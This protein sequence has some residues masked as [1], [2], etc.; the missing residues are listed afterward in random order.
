MIVN[1]TV[2]PLGATLIGTP[3]GTPGAPVPAEGGPH[4]D[5]V[6]AAHV[7][8]APAASSWDGSGSEKVPVP[9][10]LL[11]L[12]TVTVYVTGC[13]GIGF[14]GECVFATSSWAGMTKLSSATHWGRPSSHPVLV[15]GVTVAVLMTGVP[16]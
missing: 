5:P 8:V 7:Q 9:V 10:T 2:P 6:L 13:P 15:P 11:G 1:V 3:V 4:V 16:S 14:S 12:V